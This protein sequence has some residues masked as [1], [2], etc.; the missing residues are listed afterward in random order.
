MCCATR[1]SYFAGTNFKELQIMSRKFQSQML[2][3]AVCCGFVAFALIVSS[4][5][6]QATIILTQGLGA[7]GVASTGLDT[8]TGPARASIAPVFNPLLTQVPK[9]SISVTGTG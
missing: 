7:T 5:A 8:T 6:A 2:S 3:F 1:F 4:P 9:G